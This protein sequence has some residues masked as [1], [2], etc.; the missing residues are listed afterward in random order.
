MINKM[1]FGKR[2]TDFRHKMGLSQSEL[3]AK[4]GVSAQAVSKWENATTL[5]DMEVMLALS[6]LCGVTMNE[7]LE[8]N[9]LISRIASRPFESNNG[10]AYF[11][12]PTAET[13]TE[14][15]QWEQA[16][17]Q[18][19]WIERNWRDY[20]GQRGGWVD[21]EGSNIFEER[22][23]GKRKDA[24]QRIAEHGGVILDIGSGPGGGYMPC[25]LQTDLAAR[26]IVSDLSHTVVEEWKKFL[27]KEL[28]SPHLCYAAFDFCDIPFNDCTIDVV[29]DHAGILNCVGDKSAALREVY[30]VLKPGGLFVS[31]GAFVTKETLQ[32]LPENIRKD[33]LLEWPCVLENLYEETML[34][35]FRKIDSEVMD[36]FC[37]DEGNSDFADWANVRGINIQFTDYVRFCEK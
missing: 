12:S 23:R 13:G 7:M 4:I 36:G 30:R 33:L 28:D 8:D 31:S 3:A 25:I 32:A 27:D 20:W 15:L 6:N 22:N 11:V 37:T 21:L 14:R 9:S 16:M 26:I 35:G 17:R 29:S 10:I 2:V 1:H 34:A 18:E 19:N 24:A 5:P